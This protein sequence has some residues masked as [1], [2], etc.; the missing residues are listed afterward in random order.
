MSF[1]DYI[2]KGWEVIKLQGEAIDTLSKDEKGFGPGLGILAI[3]GV[4]AAIGTLNPPGIIFMPIMLIV[5]IFVVVG[6]MHFVATTFL[7]GQGQFKEV[8]VP[9]SCAHLLLWVSVIPILGTAL[10]ALA[11]IWM[12]VVS[13]II[14]ERTHKIDRG[15][16]IVVVAVPV[17][18][19]IIVFFIMTIVGVGL[20][21]LTGRF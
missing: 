16:A 19:W 11:A 9:L 1:G 2:K 5:G 12:L 18:L 17:V 7:G 13:V 3:A 20:M 8:F 6:I 15:K 4:C 21:A 10:S 14:I